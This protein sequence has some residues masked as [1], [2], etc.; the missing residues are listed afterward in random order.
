MKD[1]LYTVA[2]ISKITGYNRS[3]V[4]RWLSKEKVKH[5]SM[6]GNAPLYDAQVLEKFKKSHENKES[7]PNVKDEL[8]H[9]KDARIK[10]L[11]EQIDLLKDQ[12]KIKDSQIQDL[13]EVTKQAQALNLTDK[14]PEQVK[15]LKSGN[16]GAS[17]NS[18]ASTSAHK[19][20]HEVVED[21][22]L[23]QENEELKKK[24]DEVQHRGFWKRLFNKI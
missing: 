12:L 14:D 1:K 19:E 10:D 16:D 2:D 17:N 24:L 8:V 18:D 6:R 3:T 11:Q 5:A 7:K 23:Q 15:L 22:E 13:T 9:E 20:V 21:V 4:T